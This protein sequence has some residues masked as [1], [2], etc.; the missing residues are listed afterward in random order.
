M[1]YVSFF[2][3][4]LYDDVLTW[5]R[6][7]DTAGSYKCDGNSSQVNRLTECDGHFGIL[8]IDQSPAISDLF[9]RMTLFKRVIMNR[10]GKIYYSGI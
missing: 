1:K 6:A 3:N 9:S 7:R 8:T 2:Y 4:I 5:D 10:V